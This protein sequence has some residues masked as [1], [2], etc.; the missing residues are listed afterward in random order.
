MA[1]PV[2]LGVVTLWKRPFKP[3]SLTPHS[4]RETTPTRPAEWTVLIAEPTGGGDP[5]KGHYDLHFRIRRRQDATPIFGPD[6]RSVY[7]SSRGPDPRT[8]I[9]ASIE[10]DEH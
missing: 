10:G 4:R 3:V 5:L 6:D 9:D 2:F 7:F 8:G 1:A